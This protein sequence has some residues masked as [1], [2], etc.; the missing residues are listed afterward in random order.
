MSQCQLAT[1]HNMVADI[2]QSEMKVSTTALYNCTQHSDPGLVLQQTEVVDEHNSIGPEQKSACSM[3]TMN[4]ELR[5]EQMDNTQAVPSL[6][7]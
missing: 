5:L 6:L 4:M 1:P 2:E 3:K 7:M